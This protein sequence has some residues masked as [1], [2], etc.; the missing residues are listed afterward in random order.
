MSLNLQILKVFV[1]AAY[2]NV[3]ASTAVYYFAKGVTDISEF[4][5]ALRRLEGILKLPEL[6][7]ERNNFHSN[8]KVYARVQLG[9]WSLFEKKKTFKNKLINFL[10]QSPLA[11]CLEDVSV[12]W[13]W[14]TNPAS[15]EK[16]HLHNVT[17]IDEVTLSNISLSIPNG[18]LV[19][20]VGPMNSGKTS[21]LLTIA[22]ELPIES[23]SIAING[24][25]SIACQESWVFGGSFRQN[26]LFGKPMNR[27]RFNAV[28]R[29]CD[30]V[31]DLEQLT[32]GEK[33]IIGE[34]GASLSCGQKARLRFVCCFI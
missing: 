21:L 4:V 1:L 19:A 11:I 16:E 34:R 10:V 2:L 32:N 6:N 15:T 13:L 28:L 22:G 5:V 3:V 25:I 24:P 7:Q 30:L 27:S 18:S 8:I 26:I 23:G 29:E 14:S 31:K 17:S 33:T 9:F 20:I 12:R